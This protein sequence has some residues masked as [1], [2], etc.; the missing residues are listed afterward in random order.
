MGT[1]ISV[2]FIAYAIP[3]CLVILFHFFKLVVFGDWKLFQ[4]NAYVRFELIE[5]INGFYI[6]LWDRIA[7]L[8]TQFSSR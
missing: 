6:A 2:I 8:W 7:N 4:F 5:Q 3:F 1:I